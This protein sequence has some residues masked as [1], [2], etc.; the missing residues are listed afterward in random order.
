MCHIKLL[1]S[2][3]DLG[4]RGHCLNLF[5]TYLNGRKQCCEI[6][7]TKSEER[8][9]EYGIPQGTVL[10]PI[11]F[12]KYINSLFNL[13]TI[14]T[15]ISFA[16][17][18]VVFYQQKTWHDL[19]LAVEKDF[20]KIK[21]WFDY[22]RLTINFEKTLYI[23]FACNK[24]GLPDFN[25][26]QIICQGLNFQIKEAETV[27]YLGVTID[28][29]LRW[30]HHVNNVVQT[31]RTVIY[32]FKNIRGILDIKNM[33]TLY[34]ALVESRL[35]Y[36]IIAWGSVVYGYLRRLEVIQ[37]KILKIIYLKKHTYPSD[38][39]Y[40]ETETLDMRK[41]YFLSVVLHIFKH[42]NTLVDIE[43][44]YE[45]RHRLTSHQT[46]ACQK[47]IGQKNHVYLAPR[48]YNSLPENIKKFKSI[49]QFKRN[50][51]EYLISAS[52]S[53]IKNLIEMKI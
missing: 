3:E 32:K 9:V 51:K 8:T 30:D 40:K 19:K 4:F 21:N 36:G 11:L 18:T 23:P 34:Y 35:K 38:E 44:T 29:H 45:T 17:D 47:S 10:G 24:R 41:L 15:I 53:Y 43:H 42:K 27:K 28:R 33:K 5:Q 37:K 13:D 22:K 6:N 12:T 31:L 26:L 25:N 39:L 14:G 49:M 48:L 2:L 16:D 52:R 50:T 20:V 1:Q 46:P 7:S